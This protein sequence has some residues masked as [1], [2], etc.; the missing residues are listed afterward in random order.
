MINKNKKGVSAVVATVLIVMITVAAVA[1]IWATVIPMIK[2]TAEKGLQCND[3]ETELTIVE[4]SYTCHNATDN[5]T[6]QISR[7]AGDEI[8]GLEIQWI[9][10]G[11]SKNQTFGSAGIPTANGMKT[12]EVNGSVSPTDLGGYPE[13]VSVSPVIQIGNSEVKCDSIRVVTLNPCG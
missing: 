1:I 7:K 6:V 10:D 8:I 4:N 3:A 12:Y 9:R 13:Q 5:A 11:T 2:N